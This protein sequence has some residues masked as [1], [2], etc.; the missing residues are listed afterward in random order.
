MDLNAA[1]DSGIDVHFAW[2]YHLRTGW[3]HKHGHTRERL[4]PAKSV[5]QSAEGFVFAFFLFGSGLSRFGY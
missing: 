3:R 5:G 1:M 2:L 4:M